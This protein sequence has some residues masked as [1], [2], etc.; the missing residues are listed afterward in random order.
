MSVSIDSPDP[1][2]DCEL[3]PENGDTKDFYNQIDA[4]TKKLDNIADNANN[5]VH[6]TTSGNKHIPS[7]GSSGQILRW[8]E[9]GTAIWGEENDTEIESISNIDLENMLK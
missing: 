9:D 4:N 7:G 8:L 3:I 1:S 6:P 5:Y 2:K